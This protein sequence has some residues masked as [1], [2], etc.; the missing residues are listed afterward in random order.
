MRNG[1]YI[2]EPCQISNALVIFAKTNTCH[3]NNSVL[4]KHEVMKV[5]IESLWLMSC[6][7]RWHDGA[8]TLL[9][10]ELVIQLA[11]LIERRGTHHWFLHLE[12][13]IHQ[14]L[15]MQLLLQIL[16]LSKLISELWLLNRR[17]SLIGGSII[18]KI[19]QHHPCNLLRS[20]AQT[21]GRKHYSWAT[22]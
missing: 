14:L 22:T 15:L 19:W 21:E 17:I 13:G 3:M 1:A 20:T 8:C 12:S 16:K 7:M 5:T 18:S 11:R 9:H 2:G 4:C 6:A 10:L